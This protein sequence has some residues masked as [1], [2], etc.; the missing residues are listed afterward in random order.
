MFFNCVLNI[1]LPHCTQDGENALCLLEYCKLTR[2]HI[3]HLPVA[4]KRARD[5]NKSNIFIFAIAR[6][7]H[8]TY[9]RQYNAQLVQNF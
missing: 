5:W 1:T 4:C 8:G 7:G 9:Q 2:S 3:N 6:Q